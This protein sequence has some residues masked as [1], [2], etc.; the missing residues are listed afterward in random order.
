MRHDR[1]GFALGEV[2]LGW[3]EPVAGGSE[4]VRGFRAR[5][6]WRIATRTARRLIAAALVLAAPACGGG[7][8]S[9]GD[10]PPTVRRGPAALP[11]I[12]VAPLP[13]P[14]VQAARGTPSTGTPPPPIV[15][16]ILDM[17]LLVIA[18]TGQEEELA[19]LEQLLKHIGT[20]YDKLL[21]ASAP[22][23]STD[24]LADG[25][26]GKYSGVIL[27]RGQLLLD[28]GVSA[29]SAAEW[30][31]LFA[32]EAGFGV[33]QLALYTRPDDAGGEGLGVPVP[34]DTSRAPLPV[35]CTPAGRAVFFDVNCDGAVA[36]AG[37]PAYPAPVVDPAATALLTEEDGQAL[38]SVKQVP[39]GR[40]AMELSFGQTRSAVHSLQLLYGA[41][42]WTLH[43]LFLGERQIYLGVQVDDLF[44]STDVANSSGPFR[45]SGGELS[46]AAAWQAGRRARAST[47][48]LRLGFG[49]SAGASIA[50]AGTPDPLIAAAQS[51]GGGFSWI[52]GTYD[53]ADLGGADYG[54]AYQEVNRNI[55][56]VNALGLAPFSAASLIPPG[57]SG[58][59]NA[60]A[61]AAAR[62]L[63]VR[64]VVTDSAAAGAS[65][66]SPNGSCDNPTPNAGIWNAPQPQ[67]LMLPRRSNNLFLNVTTP[68]E[69][70]AEYNAI[71]SGTWG[72]ALA[73]AEILD[74]ESDVLVG[75]LMMGE[76]D[77]WMFHQA[78]LH[79]YGC[80]RSL[81]G[82]LLDRTF[83][84]Y[85]Q[86][87]L[88]AAISPTMDDLG[89]RFA[90]RMRYDAAGATATI[91]PGATLTL[92]VNSAASVPVTGLCS[93]GADRYAGQPI[94]RVDV[95]PGADVTMPLNTACQLPAP[96][97]APAPADG[98]SPACVVA[99]G[100]AADG[101][102]GAH[103]DAGGAD[104]SDISFPYPFIGCGCDAGGAGTSAAR[105]PVVLLASL[106]VAAALAR[107]RTRRR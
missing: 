102:A 61:M 53:H 91:G 6:I 31:A 4:P 62:D 49:V 82:D 57:L 41:V 12:T 97:A 81:L 40:Q 90:D 86:R 38:A 80:G 18:T 75:Y 2:Q 1:A 93:A 54:T 42:S 20:P 39:D 23:L 88:A 35:T 76:S 70:A 24:Q 55:Q 26:H 27:T 92:H 22:Q 71:Y 37:V 17:K 15:N 68:D 30:A 29:F 60:A 48:A 84:K 104:G 94:T 99:D 19:A 9:S 98:G 107:R 78:N 11:T 33:R 100:G 79:V 7:G 85:D 105:G 50:A 25:N 77:P 65:C 56:R 5:S 14:V 21:A 69:W 52:D 106:A 89:Q 36:I 59:A 34:I 87:L 103:A 83:D 72:R 66:G 3:T 101:G 28:S 51:I 58:L 64:Y 13:Q 95:S 32:Y 10:V 67:I 46:G 8:A 16:P 44:V 96:A 47:A 63:G 43:G 74:A 73:Y 45:L